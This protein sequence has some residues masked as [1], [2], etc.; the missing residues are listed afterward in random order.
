MAQEKRAKL[1]NVNVDGTVLTFAFA[2]GVTSTVD[3][4]TWPEAMQER[5]KMHGAEQK[6]R[7]A[8]AGEKTP[9]DARAAMLDVLANVESGNWRISRE[10]VEIDT[11][12]ILEALVR[13]TGHPLERVK[14]GWERLSKEERADIRQQPAV[15]VA[16]AEIKK[17]RAEKET[18]K[19]DAAAITALF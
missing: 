1:A 8:Y 12:L 9:A 13:I 14:A 16:M 6:L 5:A 11:A 10:G 17:E 7:D 4:S 18:P 3:V 19:L 2:D 15:K